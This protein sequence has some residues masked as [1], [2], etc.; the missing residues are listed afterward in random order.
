MK[1]E[2]SVYYRVVLGRG[3]AGKERPRMDGSGKRPA[4]WAVAAREGRST[5]PEKN[6]NDLNCLYPGLLTRAGYGLHV[7]KLNF[8]A[9]RALGGLRVSGDWWEYP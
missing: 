9:L 7:R 3:V 4:S 6:G 1:E 2:I 8:L 5:L